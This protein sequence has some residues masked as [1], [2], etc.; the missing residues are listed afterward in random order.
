MSNA[1]EYGFNAIQRSSSRL[2]RRDSMLR[3]EGMFR[4]ISS[5]TDLTTNLTAISIKNRYE[6]VE[7]RY[8][9]RQRI[10]VPLYYPR[11]VQTSTYVTELRRT[12]SFR[13]SSFEN[14][15]SAIYRGK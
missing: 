4:R 6:E 5:P 2:F 15:D 10:Y 8:T 1:E 11:G 9:P 14:V 12:V 3:I 7:T 13:R